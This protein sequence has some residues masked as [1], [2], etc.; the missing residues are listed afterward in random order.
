LGEKQ[1]GSGIAL[2]IWVNFMREILKRQPIV[3]QPEP[4]G[5]I[6]INDGLFTSESLPTNSNE[7]LD[8]KFLDLE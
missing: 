7:S 2:P 6:R 1:T 8:V 3:F 4:P 5:I